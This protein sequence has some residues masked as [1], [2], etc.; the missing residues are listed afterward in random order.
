MK[1]LSRNLAVGISFLF[2]IVF[3]YTFS[4]IVTFVL[5][6]WVLSMIGQPLMRFF[7][8]KIRIGKFR[9]GAAL[10]AALTLFTYFIVLTFL[11]IMFVP[12]I[13]EQANNLVRV[14][15]EAFA[16]ALEDPLRQFQ[17]WLSEHNIN[18]DPKTIENRFNETLTSSFNPAL[19]GNFFSSVLSAAGSIF[20]SSFSVLFITF[21]FLKEKR[22][23]LN[24]LLALVPNKYE[25]EVVNSVDG[26]SRLLTRYFGGILL[27]IFIITIYVSFFLG[28]LGVKNALLIGFFAGV[29]NVIPYLGPVIGGIFGILITISS[30]LDVDFYTQ[31]LPL[32]IR[33]V[34]VFG[35]VQVLDNFILQPFIFSTSVLAHPLEIFLI[36]LMG[37]QIGGITGMILAIPAYTVLRVVARVFLSEFK[38]VQKITDRILDHE[39]EIKKLEKKNVDKEPEHQ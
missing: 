10:S 20:I 32:L 25:K 28:I 23:F 33:V 19:I 26:I 17:E 31:M 16:I 36:I 21:F 39:E 22:L 9:A 11:L 24:F 12:L 30:N 29:I 18:W 35:T 34:I 38:L 3:I 8:S 37:A 27:Q 4:E 14:D 5:I 1:N 2:V 15:Y 7:Q 6:S 13:V